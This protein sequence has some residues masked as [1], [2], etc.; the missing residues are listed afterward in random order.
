MPPVGDR[1]GNVRSVQEA[2]QLHEAHRSK[3]DWTLIILEAIRNALIAKGEVFADDLADLGVP[4]EH[5]SIIGSQFAR[6]VN[7]GLIEAFDRRRCLHP[8]ANGRKANVYR[9]TRFGKLK[10]SEPGADASTLG[11]AGPAEIGPRALVWDWSGPGRRLVEYW[12]GVE[13]K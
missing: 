3:D 5:Q 7:V 6:L 10:L 8:A 13:A 9:P 11:S 1:G 12:R 4:P 2:R